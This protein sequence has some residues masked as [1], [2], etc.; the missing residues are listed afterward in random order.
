MLLL[1]LALQQ[2]SAPAPPPAAPSPI[3]S[4]RIT[5]EVRTLTAGDTLRLSAEPLDAGGNPVPNATVRF[6]GSGGRFEGRVDSTGL[7]T[8][9]STGTL[10]VS[11]VASVAGTRPVIQRVEIRMLPG[12]PARVSIQPRITRVVAGQ[13]FSLQS[14]SYSVAGDV[15]NDKARWR[16]S[17]PRIAEATSDG[18]LIAHSPGR[19][20]ITARV[21]GVEDTL[22]VDV[23]A[24]AVAA[25]EVVPAR[26]EARQGDVI[27]FKLL[28]RDRNGKEI[29]GLTP[30]WSFS[31]GQGAIDD[32]GAFVGY[33]AGQ[34]VLTGTMGSRSANAI[35]NLVYRDVRRPATVVGRLAAHPILHRGGLGPPERQASPTSAPAVAA[36]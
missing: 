27:R 5:P 8:A 19:A 34:Y 4:V 2:P 29:P 13:M 20:L 6:V 30:R 18:V 15:R 17:A 9:G 23:L 28:A 31:P 16:S 3:S 14:R 11:A 35:V 22:R 21:E 36:T 24:T 7:V 12:A 26:I 10:G 1:L 32:D 33:S 25:V